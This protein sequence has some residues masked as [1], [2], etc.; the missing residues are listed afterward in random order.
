MAWNLQHEEELRARDNILR[1]QEEERLSETEVVRILIEESNVGVE[2]GRPLVFS[3]EKNREVE[4]HIDNVLSRINTLEDLH[5]LCEEFGM[6]NEKVDDLTS[7]LG[8]NYL[9][10]FG[11]LT[12]S[13]EGKVCVRE[14]ISS[15]IEELS[16]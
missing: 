15:H 4:M 12:I 3:A 1:K 14:F 11:E 9:E 8:A 2:P 5:L 13:P 16:G 6:S 7:I 10:N